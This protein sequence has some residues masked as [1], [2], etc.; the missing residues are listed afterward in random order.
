MDY[1]CVVVCVCARASWRVYMCCTRRR[2]KR[3]WQGV[4]SFPIK[5]VGVVG[6]SRCFF[7][8][9]FHRCRWQTSWKTN[10]LYLGTLQFQMLRN[11]FLKG[12]RLLHAHAL[13][14]SSETPVDWSSISEQVVACAPPCRA[15]ISEIISYVRGTDPAG[16]LLKEL[17]HCQKSYTPAAC[18]N[19]VLGSEF[20]KKLNGLP[21]HLLNFKNALIKVNLCGPS[22]LDRLRVGPKYRCWS[23][24]E[25]N[26]E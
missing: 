4:V 10:S 21:Q 6:Y 1:M 25:Q 5:Y 20:L 11:P 26:S 24:A 7:E 8:A 22:T 9:D 3:F 16:E 2:D 19:R 15:W 18:T 14:Q 12:R 13:W 17:A 23:V